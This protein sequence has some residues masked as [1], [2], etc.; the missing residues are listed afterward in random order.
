MAEK[1]AATPVLDG[2]DVRRFLKKL[3][4]PSTPK[5]IE[6]LKRAEEVFKKIKFIR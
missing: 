3:E 1:V 5:E 2:E 4:T 6:D